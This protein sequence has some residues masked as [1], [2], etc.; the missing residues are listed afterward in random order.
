MI[1]P[2]A[3][4][5]R[6]QIL[7]LRFFESSELIGLADNNQANCIGPQTLFFSRERFA[8]A[9]ALKAQ[10]AN[11]WNPPLLGKASHRILVDDKWQMVCPLSPNHPAQ[12]F[13]K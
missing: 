5:I 13:K 3:Q 8:A 2:L 6:T 1:A 12:V 7:E 9:F 4:H 11:Q 10:V